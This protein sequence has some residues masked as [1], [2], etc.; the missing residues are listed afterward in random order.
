MT[1]PACHHDSHMRLFR[2]MFA[3]EMDPPFTHSGCASFV[4]GKIGTLV[5]D[6]LV[7]ARMGGEMRLVGS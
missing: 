7:S 2:E 1:G 4:V 5:A 3:K 6:A